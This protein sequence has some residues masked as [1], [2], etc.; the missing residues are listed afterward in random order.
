MT[1]IAQI[2]FIDQNC[3]DGIPCKYPV[4]KLAPQKFRVRYLVK[5]PK[6]HVKLTPRLCIA[7]ALY[8]NEVLNRLYLLND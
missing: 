1:P 4:K 8:H 2:K 6:G 3:Q 7:D 5:I